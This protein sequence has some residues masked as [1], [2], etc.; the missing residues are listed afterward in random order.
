MKV[1]YLLLLISKSLMNKINSKRPNI[2]P[3]CTPIGFIKVWIVPH[4][5]QPLDSCFYRKF[6]LLN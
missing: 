4:L 6:Y 3:W 2:E 5:N 1:S